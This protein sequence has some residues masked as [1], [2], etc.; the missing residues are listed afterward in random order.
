MSRMQST[1]GLYVAVVLDIAGGGG[2]R[3][4]CLFSWVT[5][6]FPGFLI[7]DPKT[8]RFQKNQKNFNSGKISY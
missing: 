7:F 4:D 1:A 5:S 2:V 8:R 3:F 6:N